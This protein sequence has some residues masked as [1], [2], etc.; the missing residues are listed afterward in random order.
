VVG[1]ALIPIGVVRRALA[2]VLD[3]LAI[4]RDERATDTRGVASGDV[5]RQR[6][7]DPLAALVPE[8][9]AATDRPGDEA[10]R[11]VLVGLELQVEDVEVG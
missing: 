10:R 4:P 6:T 7:V 11:L 5:D 8:V 3:G 1:I 9:M 2:R